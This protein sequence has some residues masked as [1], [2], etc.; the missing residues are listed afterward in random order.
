MQMTQMPQ[1]FFSEVGPILT[2]IGKVQQKTLS[3]ERE[4]IFFF[5]NEEIAIVREAVEI[6]KSGRDTVPVP[7]TFV[8]ED[9]RK[10]LENLLK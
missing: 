5:N 8:R 9:K 2:Q 10:W 1:G 6:K 3:E 4:R 7:L